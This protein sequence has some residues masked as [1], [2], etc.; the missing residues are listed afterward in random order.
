MRSGKKKDLM[1]FGL[2][3]LRPDLEGVSWYIV[4]DE[5][6]SPGRIFKYSFVTKTLLPSKSLALSHSASSL[7]KYTRQSYSL[8]QVTRELQKCG[9][10][11]AIAF[12]PPRAVI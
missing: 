3:T 9:C 6:M 8:A 1:L 2:A 12:S 7:A 4:W 5:R 11:M 10:E